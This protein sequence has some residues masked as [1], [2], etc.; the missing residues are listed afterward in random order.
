M[1]T[2]RRIRGF[3]DKERVF[4]RGVLKVAH[5][6]D[7]Y[8]GIFASNV[9]TILLPILSRGKVEIYVDWNAAT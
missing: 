6:R 4:D 9:K 2:S 1:N 7:C 5:T 3:L 8:P